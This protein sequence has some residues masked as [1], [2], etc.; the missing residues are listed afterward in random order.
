VLQKLQEKA[1]A[2]ISKKMK[3]PNLIKKPYQPVFMARNSLK[4][5]EEKGREV[6]VDSRGLM[7][8]Q[9]HAREDD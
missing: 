2:I 5:K 6:Q 3:I 4:Q 7:F 1:M 9:N 8:L